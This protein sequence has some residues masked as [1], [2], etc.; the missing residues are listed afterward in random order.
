MS[1]EAVPLPG[2]TV[3]TMPAVTNQDQL[4][5]ELEESPGIG[6]II[7]EDAART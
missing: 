3:L 4:G 7:S 5:S 1:E 6:E 2:E